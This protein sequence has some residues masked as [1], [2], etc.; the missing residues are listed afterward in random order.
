MRPGV[1]MNRCGPSGWNWHG[2]S[3]ASGTAIAC[4]VVPE[5]RTSES[6]ETASDLSRGRTDDPAEET[7][8]LCARGT[9]AAELDGSESGMGGGFRARCRGLRTSDPG[10]ECSRCAHA[11]MFGFGSGHEF[12]QSESNAS[13]EAP[14]GT[15]PQ[16]SSSLT[17]P[18]LFRISVPKIVPSHKLDGLEWSGVS[19]C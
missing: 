13:V 11:R 16:L 9:T 17:T 8:A 5:R 6:Q 19:A 4:A 15:V 7:Q 10:A 14:S 18:I 1:R 12:C 2:R 3:R